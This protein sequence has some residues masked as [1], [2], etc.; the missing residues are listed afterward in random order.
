MSS[1]SRAANRL[2]HER[3]PYLQQHAHDAVNWYP[4]SEEAFSVAKKQDKLIFLSVGYA[5]CHWCHVM[6][7]ESFQSDSTGSLMNELF[8][9]IKVD[10]EERPDVDRIYMA[11]VQAST[12][13]GGWPMS[14]FLTPELT[15][16]VGGTYFPPVD[17][18][19]RPSFIKVCT[20][21]AALW[22][23]SRSDLLEQSSS[24]ISQMRDATTK[25]SKSE[26]GPSME[27]EVEKI[28]VKTVNGFGSQFDVDLGGFGGAPKFPRPVI[29]N[30]LLRAFQDLKHVAPA[31]GDADGT[32]S[33]QSLKMATETLRRMAKGG[34]H[35]H[36]GGGFHRYS[37]DEHWHVPH[38]EKMLYDQSQLAYSYLEAFQITGET[39]YAD[40][41]RDVLD[42]VARDLRGAD[43]GFYSAEDADS[44]PS[45]T[46]SDAA[47]RFEDAE[48]H[49]GEK[50]EGAFY[51]W[52][53][54][55]IKSILT[56]AR[57][58][59]V[60]CAMFDVRENGNVRRGSD[61]QGEFRGLNVL[62]KAKSVQQI[63]QKFAISV[64]ETHA[65][66][67]ASCKRLFEVRNTRPRPFLD[68]KIVT[69]WNGLMIGAFAKAS[70]VLNESKYLEI[71]H[72]AA[73]F[74]RKNLFAVVGCGEGEG[75]GKED[76]MLKEGA[77]DRRPDLVKFP[78]CKLLRNFR[79]TPSNIDGFL[80]DYAY[81]IHGLLDLYQCDGNAEW[82]QW[83]LELQSTQDLLFWDPGAG[84]YFD[85]DGLDP[86]ILIRMKEDYD[87]AE[88]A[89]NSI[90]VSNLQRLGAILNKP[91]FLERSEAVVKSFST[92]L[93]RLSI[94]VPQMMVGLMG[95]Y[96][97]KSQL[98]LSC[99]PDQSDA[100]RS[101][102][103]EAQRRFLPFSTIVF[104]DND[105]SSAF[106]SEH[107]SFLE[108]IPFNATN[109]VAYFCE[110]YACQ[111]P[112]KSPLELG[113]LL[114][115]RLA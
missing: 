75:G 64:E 111:A 113:T 51:V 34:M 61:P 102:L 67:V 60:F 76:V 91:D 19:Y 80:S 33:Q 24:I 11:F 58:Y 12:G 10:R 17:M 35:D 46:V 95:Q 43:G 71:A 109:P 53:Q 99:R 65:S 9:N 8:V 32:D 22:K 63:A 3:S 114:D 23:E 85:T 92:Q 47:S 108:S 101:M 70:I 68:D 115:S 39:V 44:L 84:N 54:K 98:V 69:G 57:E 45:D 78:H 40:V 7:H 96:R 16:I 93:R 37:V 25:G 30:F 36:I 31:K 66:L 15:P 97:P 52:T 89:G 59:E 105:R 56:D 112:C 20:R 110:N 74:I 106:L 100:A 103:H 86:T 79:N 18:P 26:A 5:T 104:L 1:A 81:L 55:E 6:Q 2:L 21:V 41:A 50:K 49:H 87:G 38:F 83:A 48:H 28:V 73:R 29:L 72:Q 42:Y 82:L 14:V 4:W 88:P 90:S 107:N 94:G 77:K 62:M 13:S 27:S